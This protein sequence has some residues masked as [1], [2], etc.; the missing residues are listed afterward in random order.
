MPHSSYA[1]GPC[2]AE[3][4]DR[5]A[6]YKA[7]LLCM[8]HWTRKR[9][10]GHTRLER[11]PLPEGTRRSD[12]RGY[13]T[14]KASNHPLSV[15]RGQQGWVSEHRLVAY[16]ARGGKIAGCEWCLAELTWRSAHVDH[17]DFN[18]RNNIPSNLR[19]SCLTCNASRHPA[20]D[21]DAWVKAVALRRLTNLRATELSAHEDD[22]RRLLCE[23]CHCD[24]DPNARRSA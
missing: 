24:V 9:R 16:D 6:Y 15:A 13:V 21:M 1:H 14:I 18:P 4:C 5:P 12:E 20:A 10:N 7:D 23:D 11:Q 3:G 17:I 19:V 2:I 8:K 22:V